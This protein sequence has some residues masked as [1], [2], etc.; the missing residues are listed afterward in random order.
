MTKITSDGIEIDRSF[1]APPTKVF[2]AWTTPQHFARWFGGTSVRV[3]INHLDF[4]A[5]PGRS[6][7]AQM[8][9]PDGNTIDWAGS[10]VEVV[11]HQRLVFTITDRPSEPSRAT[12]VIV[13]TATTD[14]TQM[15]FT[16]ETPYFTAEQQEEV[17]AGWQSFIDEL[18]RIAIS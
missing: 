4:V 5:E 14:G 8:V 6:W 2:D 1:S 3:P 13:L 9:L 12:V 11:P 7:T 15:H 10:F 16:Q 17:L 18:E